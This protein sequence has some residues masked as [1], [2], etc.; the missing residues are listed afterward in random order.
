[1]LAIRLVSEPA[2][3]DTLVLPIRREG[4]DTPAA[5]VPTARPPAD[6]VRAEAIA[7]VPAARLTGEAGEVREH[8]RPGGTPARLVLLGVG[9]GDE[10]G[11]RAAGAALARAARDE[12]HIT[13]M[14]PAEATAALRGLTEGLLLGSYRF[15]LTEAGGAPALAEVDLVVAD[16]AAL[17]STLEAARTTAAMT[18]LARD[19]TNT[20]SSVKNPAWFA[21]QVEAAA[22]GHA[23]LHLRVRGP[24]E[25]AAEGFGGILAVGG[26]S[27]SG[28]RL[29]ELDWRPADARTHVVLVGKGITFDTGGISIKPVP[30]MKLMRKDM[31]G[32]AAVI[33][34]TLG[35]AALRLPVRVTTLAPLA[36]NMVSG[37]AF[38]PGDVVRHYGGLTSETTNSDAEGRLV[39]ADAMAYAVRELEPDLLVDLATLTGA[40]AVALGKRHGALYSENDRLAADLLAAIEAAGERAWRMPLPADYVEYLGSD[41]ADLHSSPD[42]GAGSVVAALF[43]R[44]FTGEL[45]DRWVHVDMSAPS[46]SEDAHAELTKGATGWGVRGLLRWLATLG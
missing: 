11:W 29:V 38:R 42:R 16:P 31:A 20:P 30:A 46:W 43:L 39:L 24:E 33:A 32:A 21:A 23:D 10:Q 37:S 18:R 5:L 6:E 36:E 17:A 22:A 15:R 13:V 26:G 8:L 28:P 45:R 44:E 40:N 1:M 14:L 34:A 7:L 9:A 12:T 2:R 3:L 19:L 4:P 25:L 41:L 27:A 35:A